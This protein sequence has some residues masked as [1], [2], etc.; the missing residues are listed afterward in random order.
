MQEESDCSKVPKLKTN[1][2]QNQKLG[3]STLVKEGERSEPSF[4]KVPNLIHLSFGYHVIWL[5][6]NTPP[7]LRH[8][9]AKLVKGENRMDT[10]D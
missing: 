8:G 10:V 1:K 2:Y 6:V 3:C 4:N 5:K 7:W 9:Q